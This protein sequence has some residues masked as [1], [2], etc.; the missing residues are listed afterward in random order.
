LLFDPG[1]TLRNR[2]RQ[3]KW[4]SLRLA[5][6]ERGISQARG[7]FRGHCCIEPARRLPV[8]G[9]VRNRRFA[10]TEMG[11][12]DRFAHRIAAAPAVKNCP[13]CT[14]RN[15]ATERV[16][17]RT[18]RVDRA[19]PKIHHTVTAVRAKPQVSG[20]DEFSAPTGLARASI[21]VS[22]PRS[23]NSPESSNGTRDRSESSRPGPT[24]RNRAVF[25]THR[26]RPP[27][28][29]SLHVSGT[30]FNTRS[31]CNGEACGR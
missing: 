15:S 9:R 21:A 13:V 24:Q 2:P 17:D 1:P 7:E 10:P 30:P 12:P 5:G 26:C 25:G 31:L 8:P 11:R 20:P 19:V 23:P 28:A 29:N 22:R 18:I 6:S 16:S 14:Q 27:T 3:T 4:R